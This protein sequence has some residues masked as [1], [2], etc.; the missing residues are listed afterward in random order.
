MSK[1]NSK[2]QT[3]WICLAT[4]VFMV[5]LGRHW[6]REWPEHWTMPFQHFFPIFFLGS[7]IAYCY[8]RLEDMDINNTLRKSQVV[9]SA[10][11]ALTFGTLIFGLRFP[12][13]YEIRDAYT[14]TMIWAVHMFLMLIGYPNTYTN[15][16]SGAIVLKAYGKY[17]FGVYLLHIIVQRK[18]LYTGMF[19][20][21]V[22][23]LFM[24]LF[25]SL[26]LGIAFYHIVEKNMIRLAQIVIRY[27][28]KYFVEGS[29][30]YLKI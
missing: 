23:K 21:Q 30:P 10:I 15:W 25:L 22:D 24:C 26:L 17:S 16:M 1:L 28:S 27:T 9:S 4:A 14:N 6:N 11:V 20:N 8:K 19:A 7:L 12:Y 5:V 3:T 13:M 18:I 2:R 29:I